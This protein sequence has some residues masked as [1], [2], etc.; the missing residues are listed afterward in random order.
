MLIAEAKLT[1]IQYALWQLPVFGA[2]IVGNWFLHR[3]SYRFQIKQIVFL[4]CLIMG[5]GAVLTTLLPYL[6]GNYYLYLLPGIIIYFFALSVVNAPL[7]RYCL[8]I[9]PVSK[10]TASALVSLSVMV[11]GALGTEAANISY[12]QHLNLHFAFY[13]NAVQ[14]LFFIC[15]ALAFKVHGRQEE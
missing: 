5:I 4:G 3:L 8:F 6:Y 13:C 10:G 14:L 9:T 15:I 1:V 2:T 11:I 7:N 12:R